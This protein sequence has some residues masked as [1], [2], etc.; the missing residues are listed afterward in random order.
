[1]IN[2]GF[3]KV[4]HLPKACH[5][6]TESEFALM[7]LRPSAVETGVCIVVTFFGSVRR[8]GR[9]EEGFWYPSAR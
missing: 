7:A 4:S 2:P 8:P 1:M 6:V 5:N 9:E 3:G